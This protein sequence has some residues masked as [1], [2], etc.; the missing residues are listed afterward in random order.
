MRTYTTL[1]L[2]AALPAAFA[3]PTVQ[4]DDAPRTVLSVNFAADDP[5]RI[6]SPA[7]AA[8]ATL[9]TD[10]AEEVGGKR[11]LKGDSRAAASEWNEFFHSKMGLFTPKEAYK[12][13]FDYRVIARAP[14]AKFYALF[15]RAGSSSGSA[16]WT[17]WQGEA[18]ATGHVETAFNTRDSADSI[19]IVGIQ[20][21]GALAINNLTI[22]ATPVARPPDLPAPKRTW[23]S[24]GG[25]SYFVDS[26]GG[27]DAGDGRSARHAWRSLGRVNAGVFGP[28]DRILLKSGSR[29]TG[30]LSPG[31]SGA[32]GKPITISSYGKG[33]KPAVDARGK[34]LATLYLSNGEY[35]DVSGL[36]IAN[37]AP[38]RIPS[39]AGVQ[40]RLENF[41]VAHGIYLHSLDIHDVFGSN[42]KDDG[43]GSGIYCSSGGDKVKTRYDGLTI[44]GCRL[45]RTDRNGIT[46]GAYYARPLWPLST[47]VVIRG[48]TL[49]D[50]GGDGIVPIG[51]DGCLIEHNI[52]R[53]G[54]TRAQDYAAGIWPWSCDNTVV[55]FNEVSGMK[56]T[57]DGEGYDSDYNSRH[58]LFQYN[59]S[60]DNDGGFM[61]ICDDGS[62]NP[63]WNIG[64]AGTVIRYNL[65]V[66]DGLHTFNITGPCQNTQIYNNVFYVGKGW[67]IPLVASGNWGGGDKWPADTRFTNNVFYVDGKARF[68]FGGMKSVV[69][70]HNAYRGAI[71]NRP[72]DPHAVLADPQLASPGS[73]SLR[74]YALRPGSPLRRAGQVIPNNGGRDFWGHPLPLAGPP[75]IGASQESGKQPPPRAR[76]RKQVFAG[77]A[78]VHAG[79]TGEQVR[80][81]LG[82]P[83]EIKSVPILT[84]GRS[85]QVWF[86]KMPNRAP[87]RPYVLELDEHDRVL[88]GRPSPR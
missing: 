87:S 57:K 27:S 39:L 4:A 31:G 23:K 32:A 67:D 73:V 47:R 65:S 28:G 83:S 42:V 44:E 56:G 49:E 64:N 78:K 74:G 34:A 8:A 21:T 72:A 62:Q 2:L 84:P 55:Q 86:Y 75:D 19:L 35:W 24:P 52:L 66:N 69:F 6:L 10:P 53:G 16:G 11:S 5:A 14:N 43:G 7:D 82:A 63:P 37:H 20:N 15:R 22:T 3:A 85:Y 1:L 60:H 54:R 18:G 61:L 46:M 13:S 38:A 58:T 45:T 12:V 48:N 33:P 81:L 79:M 9:T 50:I 26:A 80:R 77:G 40:V 41:G 76:R 68:D 51:C 71:A 70:D 36:D 29:W 59:Y 30:F 17:E 25:T 88:N